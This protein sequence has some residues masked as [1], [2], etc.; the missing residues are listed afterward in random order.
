MLIFLKGLV[1]RTRNSWPSSWSFYL[2]WSD[3][4]VGKKLPWESAIFWNLSI[5]SAN[6][7]SSLCWFPKKV[8]LPSD[9]FFENLFHDFMPRSSLGG[10]KFRAW[11]WIKLKLFSWINFTSA[12]I[13]LSG[14]EFIVWSRPYYWFLA[15]LLGWDWNK[16]K[17]IF[18]L[19]YVE[20]CPT[21]VL[22]FHKMAVYHSGIVNLCLFNKNIRHRLFGEFSIWTFLDTKLPLS[23][24]VRGNRMIS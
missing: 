15:M 7:F 22:L 11:H 8:H 21:K 23:W 1:A 6:S 17:F 24:P 18:W 20:N 19:N 4:R 14:S 16:P 12:G 9:G 3:C 10:L 5:G 2:N 13:H